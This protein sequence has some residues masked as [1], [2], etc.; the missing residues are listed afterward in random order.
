[1]TITDADIERAI[2]KNLAKLNLL[3]QVRTPIEID[4]DDSGDFTDSSAID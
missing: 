3:A 1:M 2:H 4:T